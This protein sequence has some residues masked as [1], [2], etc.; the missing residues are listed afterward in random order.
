[1]PNIIPD[2][3]EVPY[4]DRIEEADRRLTLPWQSFFRKVQELLD[5]YTP[6]FLYAEIGE[7]VNASIPAGTKYLAMP[8]GNSVILTPGYWHLSG[9]FYLQYAGTPGA[10]PTYVKCQYALSNGTNSGTPPTSLGVEHVGGLAELRAYP[11]A[12]KD[13]YSSMPM[14]VLKIQKMTEVFIV[15]EVTYP[16]NPKYNIIVGFVAQ[17]VLKIKGG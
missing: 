10:M 12:D 3:I 2:R 14:T 1:M 6:S 13:F 7:I 15:P 16:V 5:L 17:R 4:R 9:Y 8:A 11:Q